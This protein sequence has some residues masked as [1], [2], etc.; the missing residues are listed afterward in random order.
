MPSL[1]VAYAALIQASY[2]L[3][4]RDGI[5]VALEHLPPAYAELAQQAMIADHS[6]RNARIDE[7]KLEEISRLQADI[8]RH[9]EASEA[10][11][12]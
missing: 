9:L 11:K 7:G 6:A 10:S 1:D 2:T 12:N 8:A 3:G 5:N 4:T